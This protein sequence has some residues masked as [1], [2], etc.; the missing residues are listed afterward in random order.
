MQ[1]LQ[2]EAER[3]AEAASASEVEARAVAHG[4]V[5]EA[6]EARL[7]TKAARLEAEDTEGRISAMERA[8]RMEAAEQ[9]ANR[10]D[11]AADAM[12]VSGRQQHFRLH[13]I[14][15]HFKALLWES[16]IRLFNING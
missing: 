3:K 4:A 14:L 11:A 9:E 10:L 13:K 5:L 1:A 15:F 8:W 16:I 12:E 7:E 2:E 6:A